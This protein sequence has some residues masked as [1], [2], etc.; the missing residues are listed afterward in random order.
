MKGYKMIPG[1]H[2]SD[3]T[4]Q[5]PERGYN[6]HEAR[7]ERYS[8]GVVSEQMRLL[9]EAYPDIKNASRVLYPGSAADS[10]FADSMGIERVIHVDPSEPSIKALGDDGYVTVK[11]TIEAYLN[12]D[13]SPVDVLILYNPAI[14][15]F[16]EMC[17]LV[18]PNG[19]VIAN[20]WHNSA[21]DINYRVADFV[22][23]GAV[24]VGDDQ[25]F[26]DG[27]TAKKWLETAKIAI[28]REGRMVFDPAKIEKLEV[29]TYSLLDDEPTHTE[30]LWLFRKKG[31]IKSE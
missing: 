11:S 22:L 23:L 5:P 4:R 31:E 2:I 1:E 9:L 17:E 19:Y 27:E 12:D 3:V 25:K 7:T 20:N 14:G 10:T 21:A 18:R 26:R 8:Y 28:T 15:V 6:G 16:D 24:S 13:P 30:E 29:G